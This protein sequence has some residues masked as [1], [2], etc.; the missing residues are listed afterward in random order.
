MS[1][2]KLKCGFTKANYPPKKNGVYLVKTQQHTYELANYLI[3]TWYLQDTDLP[4]H[5]LA[6]TKIPKTDI[7]TPF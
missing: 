4:L 7:D 5:I 6:W 2:N 3:E 1:K